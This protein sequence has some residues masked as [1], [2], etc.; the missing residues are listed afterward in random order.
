MRKIEILY[1]W[2]GKSGRQ[3]LCYQINIYFCSCCLP[4]FAHRSWGPF[5]PYIF[6][7][8]LLKSKQNCRK[9]NRSE[10]KQKLDKEQVFCLAS[11]CQVQT[12]SNGQLQLPTHTVDAS[13]PQLDGILQIVEL[14]SCV[15]KQREGEGDRWRESVDTRSEAPTEAV[16]VG[17]KAE[18]SNSAT[19]V[20]FVLQFGKLHGSSLAYSDD[21]YI[22]I[23][24]HISLSCPLH[25]YWNWNRPVFLEEQ[26]LKDGQQGGGH[27]KLLTACIILHIWIYCRHC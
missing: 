20:F 27:H 23:V 15:W 11:G 25:K 3:D 13:V 22:L 16:H 12:V 5:T 14:F 24:H 26:L 8:Q 1:Q 9:L 7:R 18:D 2:K 4:C 10:R 17:N 6:V 19:K 21:V